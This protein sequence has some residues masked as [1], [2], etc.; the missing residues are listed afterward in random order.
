MEAEPPEPE[1]A[2]RAQNAL[3]LSREALTQ[4]SEDELRSRVI[5]PLLVA[6]KFRDVTL[7]HGGANEQGKDFV[8]W[9]PDEFDQEEWHAV[10]AKA[11]RI[12]GATSGSGSTGDV[13][14]QVLQ[15]F[16]STFPNPVT[17]AP[18]RA[19]YVT[20]IASGAILPTALTAI[21]SMLASSPL[22][23]HNTRFVDGDKLWSL[24]E[25]HLPARIVTEQLSHAAKVLDGLDPCWRVESVVGGGTV[26]YSI[27][28]R[29]VAA[30][31]GAADGVSVNLHFPETAE[32]VAAQAAL[33]HHVRTGQ[34]VELPAEFPPASG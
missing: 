5:M 33:E 25:K 22:A 11:G 8:M 17:G 15:A 16:G 29:D 2:P 10:V 21:Q 13:G 4:M 20:V 7:W 23:A 27:E 31:G 6:M 28:P 26:S 1:Q 30:P 19:T 3:G 12:T 32:G 34:S 9:K 14:T 24:I 18:V